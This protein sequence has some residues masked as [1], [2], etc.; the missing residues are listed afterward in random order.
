MHVQFGI[1]CKY[2]EGTKD[3]DNVKGSNVSNSNPFESNDQPPLGP[4]GET[5]AI[6]DVDDKTL[7]KE[8]P[9][10]KK[11]KCFKCCFCIN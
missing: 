4:N 7:K 3:D 2:K 1:W 10:K 11:K 6:V 9:K 5:E 8:E